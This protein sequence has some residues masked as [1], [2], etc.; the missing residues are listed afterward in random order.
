MS[1]PDVDA[2]PHLADELPPG[3]THLAT[4]DPY[5]NQAFRVGPLAYGLQFHVEVDRNLAEEWTPRL[6]GDINIGN[7]A[8]TAVEQGGRR[9]IGAFFDLAHARTRDG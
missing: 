9:V 7:T 2:H 5:E 4:S 1:V 6:P 3:A 8:R